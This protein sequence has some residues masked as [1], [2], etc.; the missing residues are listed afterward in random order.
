MR[1]RLC[2]IRSVLDESMVCMSGENS[3]LSC[4]RQRRAISKV[5]YCRSLEGFLVFK[6]SER[7]YNASART[8]VDPHAFLYLQQNQELLVKSLTAF[9][10]RK[11]VI[12]QDSFG[13][14]LSRTGTRSLTATRVAG[15]CSFF[16][17][18]VP[19]PGRLRLEMFGED[20]RLDTRPASE[21]C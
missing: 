8:Q 5:P 17:S 9:Q 7:G 15:H 12:R 14:R 1:E 2:T 16:L 21:H 11:R 3:T 4:K 18:R 6:L 13:I 20:G 10:K 19:R